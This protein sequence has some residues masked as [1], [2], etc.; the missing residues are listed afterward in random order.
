MSK[1]TILIIGCGSIGERH[2]RCFLDTGRTAVT[3]CDAREE[4]LEE[5]AKR[6]P[7][8]TTT[9]WRKAVDRNSFTAAVI[10]TPAHHHVE[11]GRTLLEAGVHVLIEKPLSHALTG[12]EE[13]CRIHEK[14]GKQAAVAYVYHCFPALV[15]ARDFIREN[16][17]GPILN[18]TVVTGQPFH[19]LR[20]AYAQT[21]YADRSQGGGAIQ[22]ALTH[23][24]NWMESVVGPADS[25]FCDHGH[26]ALPDVEVEDTV[27]ISARHGP[28]LVSYA[29][30]QFQTPNESFIQFD[31]LGGSIRIELHRERW[32]LLREGEA[33]WTWHAHPVTSRDAHFR[34]QAEAFLQQI[35]DGQPRLCSLAAAHQTVRF[36]LAALASATQGKR[37]RCADIHATPDA[38]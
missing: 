24:A 5:L 6:Y 10:C 12:I 29:L 22:D 19:Q 17:L 34:A 2:L 23:L 36:N 35:D 8:Q 27:H 14:S 20:P 11:M 37:I 13:L 21:Y 33:D 9:D 38:D 32:G 3:A 30:N 4:R 1:S 18:A 16:A 26:Q 25:L 31:A 7:V 15:A 28:T